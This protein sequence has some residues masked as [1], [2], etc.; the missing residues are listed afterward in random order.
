MQKIAFLCSIN[1]NDQFQYLQKQLSHPKIP[2][3]FVLPVHHPSNNTPTFTL[4]L[5]WKTLPSNHPHSKS[6]PPG[7]AY[8]SPKFANHVAK[9]QPDILVPSPRDAICT[10][11]RAARICASIRDALINRARVIRESDHPRYWSHHRNVAR[12]LYHETQTNGFAEELTSRP[13][14]GKW[15]KGHGSLCRC[16]FIHIFLILEEKKRYRKGEMGKGR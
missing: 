10:Y 14:S 3:K 16:T 11:T 4:V 2:V 15:G 7:V 9:Q 5:K 12:V 6:L 1:I 8:K 13:G